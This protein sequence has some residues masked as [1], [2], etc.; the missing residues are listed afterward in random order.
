[1]EPVTKPTRL[2]TRPLIPDRM[3]DIVV[4]RVL[5]RVEIGVVLVELH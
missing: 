1:M 3:D 4:A 5:V 2:E